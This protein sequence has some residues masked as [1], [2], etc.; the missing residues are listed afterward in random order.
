MVVFGDPFHRNARGGKKLAVEFIVMVVV[1]SDSC[2]LL[3]KSRGLHGGQQKV[4]SRAARAHPVAVK[5]KA[6]A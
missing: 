6:R 2:K 4:V 1:R 5:R 3:G